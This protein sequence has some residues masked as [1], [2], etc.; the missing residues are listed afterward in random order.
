MTLRL[1]KRS[2]SNLTFVQHKRYYT[3]LLVRY[4]KVHN[5]TTGVVS[6]IVDS[7]KTS[8]VLNSNAW[9]HREIRGSETRSRRR[10]NKGFK[11]TGKFGNR[12]LDNRYHF[13]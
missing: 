5:N 6:A 11:V 1:T 4:P 2:F 3:V 8:I 13:Y 10:S 12:T 9:F 7:F